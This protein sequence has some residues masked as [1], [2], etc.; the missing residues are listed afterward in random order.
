MRH[1]SSTMS[2]ADRRRASTD[3]PPGDGD[4]LRPHPGL[5]LRSRYPEPPSPT[6]ADRIRRLAG[7]I[8]GREPELGDDLSH[9][10]VRPGIEPG[11]GLVIHDLSRTRPIAG[12]GPSV[13]EYRG[14]LLAGDDDLVAVGVHRSPAFEAYTRRLLDLRR[15]PVHQVARASGGRLA[16]AARQD[17]TL[18]DRLVSTARAAGTLTVRPYIATDEAWGL[19][20]DI[21][22]RAGVE[23]AVAGPPPALTRRVNDKLW[24]TAQAT[25][26]LGEGSTPPAAPAQ[27]LEELVDRIR[28]L[29]GP[30]D[31]VAVRLR[32]AAAGEGN[33]VIPK[34][35]I[36]ASPPAA[37][38]S[39]LGELFWVLD[40]ADIF[41]LQVAVWESPV[42][43]SPSVQTWIPR[44]GDGR[45]LAEGVMEQ[46]FEGGGSTFC[47][48][49]PATLPS[50]VQER[51]AREAMLLATLF[52]ELGYFGRCSFDAILV[53]ADPGST[54]IH[55]VECNGRWGGTSIPMTAA[56]RLVG[57]WRRNPF[58]VASLVRTEGPRIRA[59]RA[60][61]RLGELLLEPG[62][63]EGVLLL[64]PTALEIGRG[65]DLMALAGSPDRAAWLADQARERLLG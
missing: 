7:A 21:A 34:T 16:A 41:P 10:R 54:A 58:V 51:L 38:E 17:R 46:R 25:A 5:P 11:P 65:V 56:E 2:D 13:L 15:A 18:M 36:T 4:V 52:Q 47:G 39:M 49:V 61:D 22:G 14:L 23:V 63:V 35:A 6:E 33:L 28:E 27:D 50:T 19:A 64:S 57:D 53:E 48:A 29:G 44:A 40:W 62:G 1:L 20:R 42:L 30:R 37:L 26:L 43:A 8:V 24:F 32:S 9:A 3:P 55:W 12:A 60:L 31:E 59:D 45:P